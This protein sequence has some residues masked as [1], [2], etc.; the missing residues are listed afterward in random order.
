MFVEGERGYR[1]AKDFMKMIMPSHAKNVKLY[2]ESLPLFAR[3]QVETYLG[4]MFNPTVQLKSGGY[5]VIGI[6]EALVAI[7]VNSGRSTKEGSIEDT[8]LKTNLEA[9]EEV[10]RQL[11]LRDLAGLIVIDFID[12]DER[13][14]NTAVE[15]R[16]KDKLKTDRARI[17]V[18]RISGFGLMEMSRQR[19]RPGMI[20]A[21][22]QPCN[23]CHG[24]GLIR[25]DDNLALSILRQIEEEGTR[26][27]SR[28]VL[29]KCPVGIA[30]FLMNQKREHIAQIEARYGL[31]VRIEGEPHLVSP[32]FTI[33]KFKTATRV[34]RAVETAVVSVDTSLM[35]QVDEDDGEVVADEAPA[36]AG[37]TP[38]TEPA[39]EDGEQKPKRRRRRRRRGRGKGN[40]QDNNG[41]GESETS[42]TGDSVE[43]P[44]E[45]ASADTADAVTEDVS[46]EDAP[47]PKKKPKRTRRSKS[48]DKAATDEPV[49]E[50]PAPDAEDAAPAP[51][52]EAAAETK[53]A[54]KP[55]R[56]RA[57]APKPAPEP[58]AVT[59][60]A[61]AEA[62][63]EATSPEPE[64]APEPAT[65]EPAATEPV[66]AETGVEDAP[67]KPK[68]RGWWS[69]GK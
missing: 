19:L 69:L 47:E 60:E 6:T 54:P 33:E 11:R 12:M 62:E 40:G 51:Q 64:P 63:V 16:M 9:A 46:E 49:A 41:S 30:N 8:A 20:E 57:K 65:P 27:R 58:E 32:D 26:R 31:S 56:T 48:A 2:T 22:T 36:A 13:K 14:N 42:E 59:E 34:V 53:P 15:K 39:Q 50:S 43:T 55:R 45:A 25:S 24:T 18:G 38:V 23:A 3:Y 5:I 28:E 29:V 68:K 1:T 52:A 4:G 61:P 44:V 37:S 21:T 7:D 17:Q 67:P 10:A 66:V 35:D